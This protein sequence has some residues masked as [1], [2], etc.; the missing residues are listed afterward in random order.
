VPI[1]RPLTLD[2]LLTQRDDGE[3]FHIV[4]KDGKKYDVPKSPAKAAK[5]EGNGKDNAG[6]DGKDNGGK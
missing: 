4:T 3:T 2:D 6:K 5:D 1:E